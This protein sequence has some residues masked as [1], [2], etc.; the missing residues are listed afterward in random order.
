MADLT[1]D[2]AREVSIVGGDT[3]GYELTINPDG[4]LNTSVTPPQGVIDSG[5]S[6]TTALGVSGVF[7]G[8]FVEVTNYSSVTV[9]VISDV[10]S[11]INGLV[12]QWSSDG[13]NVDRTEQSSVLAGTGRAFALTVRARYF[14]I[15]YTNG[16]TAQT[17]F[18]LGSILKP[19]GSGII[20]RALKQTITNDNFAVLT[21]ATLTAEDADDGGAYINIKARNSRLFVDVQSSTP[22]ANTVAQFVSLGKVYTVA[23]NLAMAT[24]GTDNPLILIKNP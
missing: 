21:Q 8:T 1:A 15:K 22:T 16:T 18:R 11:A 19:T 4:S 23:Q 7:T 14:R 2:E 12:F 9:S 10:A 3:N 6:S 13:T 5:N 17:T 20:T 24:A